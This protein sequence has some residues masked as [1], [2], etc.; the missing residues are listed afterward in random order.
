MSTSTTTKVVTK[1]LSKE[2]IS[3]KLNAALEISPEIDFTKLSKEELERLV[4]VMSDGKR[5][6][7]LGVTGLRKDTRDRIL[8]AV[9][10]A[11]GE[12]EGGLFGLGLLPKEGPEADDKGPLGL[13]IL[14][15][16]RR[17]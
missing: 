16:L 1:G 7:R 8:G 10:E 15:R 9:D 14:P 17:G 12:R 11:L 13:G 3:R 6:V 2:E 4:G 5:L